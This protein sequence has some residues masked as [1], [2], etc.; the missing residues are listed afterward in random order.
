[1]AE[2]GN[3]Y[4]EMLADLISLIVYSNKLVGAEK[5]LIVNF[6]HPVPPGRYGNLASQ[7]LIYAPTATGVYLR[8][9]HHL[10]PS[11]AVYTPEK[12]GLV[13]PGPGM[14]IRPGY[15]FDNDHGTWYVAYNGLGDY[16][17]G[18][19]DALARLPSASRIVIEP[20]SYNGIPQWYKL[21]P[22][23]DTMRQDLW[24]ARNGKELSDTTPL[25]EVDW[26]VVDQSEGRK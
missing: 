21:V 23:D 5:A 13:G 19:L 4:I 25:P 14:L 18:I 3:P 9:W 24:D 22:V 11:E 10:I 8:T 17:P 26:E 12:E 16:R 15:E 1:M 20:D 7:L 6:E 2:E